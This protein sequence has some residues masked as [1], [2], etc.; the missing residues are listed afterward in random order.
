[1]N[2]WVAKHLLFLVGV[3]EVVLLLLLTVVGRDEDIIVLDEA[4]SDEWLPETS[5]WFG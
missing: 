5:D 1:M 3:G 4:A 2:L